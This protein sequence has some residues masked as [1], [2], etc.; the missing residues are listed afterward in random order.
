ME[1]NTKQINDEFGPEYVIEVYNPGIGMRGFL[2]IDNTVF[3][4]GKGGMRMTENVTA[5]E[6][7]RLARAM[8]LKNA[9][10]EIPFGG[11]KSGIVWKG[12]SDQKK[13]AYIRAFAEK[14]KPFTPKYYISAPDIN[15]GEKEM[16]WFTE[17]IGIWQ[18]TTG[19]PADM[20]IKSPD[21]TKKLCGIPHEYGSTGFGVAHATRIA[22]A[23]VGFNPPNTTVA[24]QGFG[25][26]GSF[27]FK[28]L[29]G[30][31]F[32]IVAVSDKDAAVYDKNGLDNKKLLEIMEKRQSLVFYAKDRQIERDKLLEL[33]VDIL[34]PAAVTDAI[35]EGNKDKVLAKVIVEAANIP[36]REYIHEEL[37]Q[38]GILIVPDI[39]AN[40]GGVISSYVEYKGYDPKNVFNLIEEKIVKSTELVLEKSKVCGISP[41]QAAFEIAKERLLA[42]QKE[43]CKP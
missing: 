10:A 21:G 22:A 5:E 13:K 31:G 8:T 40:A 35:H 20:C 25:N 28:Y 24:I 2:V 33:P 26:V 43:K 41:R 1:T 27:T 29:A 7:F 19:K 14:V 30:M 9:L 6:V 37:W 39:A 3:G 36:M 38:K 42:K 18:A 4:P 34:I 16:R 12:G 11:A 17:T 15:V 32:K 23:R